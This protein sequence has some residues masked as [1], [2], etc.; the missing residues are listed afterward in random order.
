MQ[1]FALFLV[2]KASWGKNTSKTEIL[3]VFYLDKNKK[4]DIFRRMTNN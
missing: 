2:K 4:S 3:A 1:P